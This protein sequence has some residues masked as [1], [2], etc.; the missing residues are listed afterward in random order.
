MSAVSLIFPSTPSN[1]LAIRLKLLWSRTVL[2]RQELAYAYNLPINSP[3]LPLYYAV[4]LWDLLLRYRKQVG[5]TL[6]SDPTFT[7]AKQQRNDFVQW[8]EQG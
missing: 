1:P 7:H 3:R 4:R 5:L 8:L 6:R 2:S